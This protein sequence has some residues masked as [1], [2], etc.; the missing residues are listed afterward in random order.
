MAETAPLNQVDRVLARAAEALGSLRRRYAVIGG[1]A[2][3][4]RSVPRFTKDVDLAV[5]V[6]DDSDAEG[7]VLALRPHGFRVDVALEQEAAERLATVRLASD[8]AGSEGVLLDLLFASS[9]IEREIVDAA[10]ELQAVPGVTVPV[11]SVAHLVALKV[12]AFDPIRRPQDL[13]DLVQL[14]K[15]ATAD[16]LA[17]ARSA[18]ALV[19]ERG[20]SRGKDLPAKLDS[21][22][23][24]LRSG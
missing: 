18:L 7:L 21:V 11:A 16:D 14:L 19:A 10:D 23:H 8:E 15:V 4:A 20:F 6:S 2:V 3:S 24:A 1:L 5:V 13:A 9:G 12:L 17:R 22:L